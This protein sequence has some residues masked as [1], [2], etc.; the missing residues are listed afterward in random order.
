M[1]RVYRTVTVWFFSLALLSLWVPAALAQA[2]YHGGS[3]T[4]RQHGYEHGYRDGYESGRT[5]RLSN[6]EQDIRNQQLKAQ[7]NG[8]QPSF[9]SEMEYSQGYREGYDD[10]ARDVSNGVRSRLEELF[11]HKDPGFSP[12]RARIDPADS[13]YRDNHFSLADVAGDIGY[14]DGLSAG[15]QDRR[16]GQSYQPR[17]RAAWRSGIH[18]YDVSFGSQRAYRA[19]YRIAYEEGY[20]DGYG[21]TR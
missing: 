6:R 7:G 21:Q 20:R 19:A 8:Y 18:G 9:G 10:G 12:D 1:H 14:R 16:Q 5:S 2:D 11:V 13:I 17:R 3:L 4:A 15:V